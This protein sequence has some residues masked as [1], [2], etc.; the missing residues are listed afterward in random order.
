MALDALCLAAALRE[1]REA[2]L[3]GRID[4]IAQPG[5]HDVVLSVRGNTGNVKVFLSADPAHPRLHLT[6]LERENPAS[7]PLFCILL[8][9]HLSGARIL[10]IEQ[11][12]MERTVTIALEATN[13]L[14]D[15]VSRTL[16][17]EAMGRHADLLLLD[18]EGRIIDCTRKV[19]G[20]LASGTRQLLP[21]LFYRAPEPRFGIPPLLEREL[22]FRGEEGELSGAIQN[23]WDAV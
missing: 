1:V 6:T 13:E 19:E 2:V 16:V 5:P 23:M 17:L 22:R 20:D 4:K 11:P 12:Y 7:P 9:K 18:G 10:S 15:K 3:G 21:G 14:G 8:R